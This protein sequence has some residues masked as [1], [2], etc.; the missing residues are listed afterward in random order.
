MAGSILPA[1]PYVDAYDFKETFDLKAGKILFDISPTVF[2]DIS[3]FRGVSIQIT[4]PAGIIAPQGYVIDNTDPQKVYAVD[5]PKVRDGY[6]WGNYEIKSTIFLN[7]EIEGTLIKQSFLSPPDCSGQSN[8]LAGTIQLTVDCLKGSIT[9]R[10]FTGYAYQGLMPVSEVWDITRYY[11][12]E[13]ELPPQKI[14]K[15]PFVIEAYEGVNKFKG[16]NT[17]TYNLGNNIF[18][19]VEIKAVDEKNVRCLVDYDV[20]F[21]AVQNQL[22]AMRACDSS[23]AAYTKNFSEINALL[24]TVTA[25]SVEGKDMSEE[26]ARL[27]Q[28]LNIDCSCQACAGKRI[29]EEVQGL[30]VSTMPPTTLVTHEFQEGEFSEEF[31]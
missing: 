31:N 25:G 15:L 27:E 23:P 4:T 5:I 13:A 2:K 11:P 29:G 24:W 16:T 26:I 30:P 7:G 28:L 12:V 20:L 19:V 1:N 8:T 3:G 21:C 14:A 10:G 6:R 9:G 17:A 18:V 22:A